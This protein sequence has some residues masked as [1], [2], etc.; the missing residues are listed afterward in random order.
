[1]TFSRWTRLS[2]AVCALAWWIATTSPI[3]QV[4]SLQSPV[5][6][7][8]PFSPIEAP[9]PDPFTGP[10]GEVC[11]DI[12]PCTDQPVT[13]QPDFSTFIPGV[14]SGETPEQ[15]Q[16]PASSPDL[17]STLNYIAIAIIVVGVPLR[18]YWYIQDRRRRNQ[19]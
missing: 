7:P 8:N 6:L 19:S 2:A 4:S 16:E 13:P 17:G 5:E 12:V 11:N 9:V 14:G 15:V 18:L 3:V 10:N 1:M